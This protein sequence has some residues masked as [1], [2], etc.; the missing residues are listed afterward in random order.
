M[1]AGVVYVT[2][3]G[4]AGLVAIFGG[5]TT[6]NHTHFTDGE[7]YL[8]ISN[9][10]LFDASSQP[11]YYQRA[12][13]DITSQRDRFCLVGASGGDETTFGEPSRI[14]TLTTT[15]AE[16]NTTLRNIPV[17]RA[18]WRWRVRRKSNNNGT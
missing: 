9:I 6:T 8:L 10:S 5:Q 15:T 13:G 3:W 1:Y 11:W 2:I 17:L 16:I 14:T 4:S 18:G 12:T 7:F